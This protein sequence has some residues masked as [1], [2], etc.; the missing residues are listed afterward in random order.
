MVLFTWGKGA[1]LPEHSHP[2]VQAG[3][4]VSGAVEL[5]VEGTEYTTRSGCSYLIHANERHSARA[6]ED[7]VVLDAFTPSRQDYILRGV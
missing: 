7:S 5:T 3:F 6:L 1:V 4:V 2:H